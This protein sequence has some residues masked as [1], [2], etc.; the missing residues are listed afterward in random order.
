[1]QTGDNAVKKIMSQTLK[2]LILSLFLII[3]LFPLLWLFISSFKTNFELITKPFAMPKVWQLNNYVNAIKLSN[4]HIL[5]LHSVIIAVSATALNILIASMAAFALSRENFHLRHALLSF[6]LAGVLIPIIGLMVP[7]FRLISV[8]KIY[9]TLIALI[10]TYSAINIPISVFLL[11][12]FMSSIPKELEEAAVIDGCNFYQRFTRI[13]FPLSQL[14]IV[15]AG[16][17]VFLYAWNEFIYALLLTSS[18]KARTLQL[19]IRFFK[20]QF[21]TDYTSMFAA[22]VLTI[23]PSI[24][25]YVTFH[26]K[27]IKGLTSGA[28]KG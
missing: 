24:A 8:L 21:I 10:I 13:I 5:F 25:V 22:I 15:T 12:G 17:F 19:G 16:T 11:H 27:I 23:I 20:S 7:Y 6:I 9:D 2:W 26:D 18:L 14:G 1:M 28:V 4:L 3:T